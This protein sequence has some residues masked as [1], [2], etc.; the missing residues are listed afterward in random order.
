MECRGVFGALETGVFALLPV[1]AERIGFSQ[2]GVGLLV[3]I[4]A[5]GA[6]AMQIPV[7]RAADAVGRLA[8]LRLIS[9]GVVA[10]ALLIGLAGPNPAAVYPLVFLFVGLASAFYTV[11]LAL[12]GERVRLAAMAAA[13]AA[14]I[15]AYGLGSLIGPPAAGAAMDWANPHGLLWAFAAFAA[16]YLLVAWREKDLAKH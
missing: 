13:N 15:F 16:L 8:A 9:A 2:A 12:I 11:G 10:M 7:G 14:F 5:L 3:T 4:G 6:I 1:Y